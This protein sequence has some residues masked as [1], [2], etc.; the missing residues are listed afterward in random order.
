MEE[1]YMEKEYMEK[2]SGGIFA[3]ATRNNTDEDEDDRRH[4]VK[5][6]RRFIAG[7]GV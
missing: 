2:A 7:T 5:H 3:R 4:D 1:Q 6:I